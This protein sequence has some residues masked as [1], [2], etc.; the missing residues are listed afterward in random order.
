MNLKELVAP[1][2]QEVFLDGY[3]PHQLLHI[4]RQQKSFSATIAQFSAF[5]NLDSILKKVRGHAMVYGHCVIEATQGI[6]NRLMVPVNEVRYWYDLGA[7]IEL[8]HIG[9][10]F[11]QLQRWV[12]AVQKDL[13]LPDGTF[14]KAIIYCSPHGSGLPAHF[15]AYANF[16]TQL[17]GSKTWQVQPNQNVQD[18]MVHYDLFNYPYIPDELQSYWQG[19]PPDEHLSQ[20]ETIELSTG[21]TLFLPRGYWHKT[22]ASQDE[23]I[24]LNLTFN[25]P[26]WLD[27]LLLEIR[28]QLVKQPHW[29]ELAGGL[30]S[31]SPERRQM[32]F[33][34]AQELVS[35]LKDELATIS[36]AGLVG[37]QI[38]NIDLYQAVSLAHRQL[39]KEFL[40]SESSLLDSN[41][42]SHNK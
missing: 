2:E 33:D 30:G 17:K 18:P 5:Q 3:W 15:D 14:G 23:T 19:T 26:T 9:T 22:Q 35:A 11:P 28:S 1:I 8:D 27:L 39:H 24:S 10:Q 31:A 40:L 41:G 29:R 36:S 16:I 4:K 34:R 42:T 32:A 12:S 38:N 20:G 7:T 21:S 25:Q 13:G 37:Q 6:S